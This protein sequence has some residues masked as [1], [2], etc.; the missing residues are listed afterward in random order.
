MKVAAFLFVTKYVSMSLSA[1]IIQLI[2]KAL[3]FVPAERHARIVETPIGWNYTTILNIIFLVP[4]AILVIRFLRT[5]GL[6]MLKM[7]DQDQ[8]Q[9]G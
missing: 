5:S 2:F 8:V 1:L 6:K 3:D 4:A 7:M 9:H